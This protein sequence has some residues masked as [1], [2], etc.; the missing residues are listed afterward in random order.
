MSNNDR[1]MDLRQQIAALLAELYG[2]NGASINVLCDRILGLIDEQRSARSPELREFDQHTAPEWYASSESIAY[3]LYVDLFCPEA[4][5]GHILE[6]FQGQLDYFTE[7]GVNLLHILPIMRSSGDAGFAVDDFEQVDPRFGTTETLQQVIRT[8][9]QRGLR[10]VL[11]FVLNHVSTNHPW[12]VAAQKKDPYYS[13]FFIWNSSGEPWPD[14]PDIF[15]DFAPGHWDYV[16]EVGQ[17]VWATFYKRRPLGSDKAQSEFGQWDLNYQNPEVLVSML[18]HLLHV[19][20]WGV[21]VL[22]LDAV[23]F[24]WKE[25]GTPCVSLPQVHIILKLIRIILQAVAP[26]VTC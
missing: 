4:A 17:W 21:D 14:V 2:D 9:H 11:D 13:D 5:P 1:S 8:C 15:P 3:V 16:E 7:L 22:R 18:R 19:T 26:R 24:I 20:N 12:A 6:A 23:P 25:Y 10:I